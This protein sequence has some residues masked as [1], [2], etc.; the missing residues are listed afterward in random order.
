MAEVSRK[1]SAAKRDIAEDYPPIANVR[2]RG[3]CRKSLRLFCETYNPVTFSMP[4]CEDHLKAIARIEEAVR[5]GALYAF[6]FP[7]GSGKSVICRMAALW[8]VSYGLSRYVF[9]IGANEGKAEDTLTAVKTF[10][11]YLP[12]YAADFPEVSYPADKLGGLA[13]RAAG[14]LLDGEPTNIEW[15]RTRIML[16]TVPPPS[17][18]PKSW[19]LRSDGKVPTSGAVVSA[20]GL[21]GD[22]IRGS[23][24]TLTTGESLRPDLVLLDD[25]QTPESAASPSQNRTRERLI[26]GDVLGL[27]GPSRN[28][29][30]VMPCTVIYPGDMVDCLLDRRRHPLWRG[31]RAGILRSMPS[32]LGAWEHYREVWARCAGREPPDYAEANRYYEANRAELDAGAVASWDSRKLET[33]ISAIQHAMHLYLRDKT[34]FMSEYMNDPL[35]MVAEAI[36]ELK[37]DTVSSRLNNHDRGVVPASASRLTGFVDVQKDLLFYC[38]VAWDERFT[39]SVVD[40]GAWPD[41]RRRN[42]TLTDARPTLRESTGVGSLEGSVVAGLDGL[43]KFL[44]GREWATDGGGVLKLERCLVDSGWG[45]TADLVR[46]FCR[47]SVHAA[48]LLPSKGVGVSAAM[49]PMS[50]WPEKKGERRGRDWVMRPSAAGVGRLLLYDANAWKNFTHARLSQAVGEPGAMTLFGTDPEAHRLFAAH[51]CSEY[52]VRTTGRGRSVDEWKVRP[53]RPDNHLFDCLVGC[54]VAAAVVGVRWGEPMRTAQSSRPAVD[55]AELV[56]RNRAAKLNGR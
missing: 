36:D 19:A 18:W 42:Y 21:T 24:L 1:E 49:V 12:D 34:A 15:G 54:A 17:N 56:R 25:P 10:V 5:H 51:V 27:A 53:H 26:A 23:L 40:Y 45:Q 11:R 16:P 32:N 7:R 41:Q 3:R 8:A 37:P 47:K 14:Q 55:F 29:A 4:W 9:V 33:E 6:A 31:E 43:T 2:R 48:V 38:V 13:Q 46:Q 22:G 52:R 50:D 39:G 44:L 20:S 28:L 35:P 30:A